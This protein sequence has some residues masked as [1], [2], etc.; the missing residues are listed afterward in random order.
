[1]HIN[2]DLIWNDKKSERILTNMWN[3]Y[4]Y[5]QY[6]HFLMELDPAFRETR[7]LNDEHFSV[8]FD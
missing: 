5:K 6:E 3:Y 7:G 4:K 1:M 2:I 8:K